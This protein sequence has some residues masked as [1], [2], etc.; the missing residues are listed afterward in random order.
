M[1]AKQ[2]ITK[3]YFDIRVECT[4]PATITYRVLAETPEQA[5]ALIKGTQPSSVKH[6]LALRRET[7][8]TVYESGSTIIRLIKNL[9]GR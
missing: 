9:F 1:D 5:A 7:K 2:P 6:K 3:R 8:I 4:L